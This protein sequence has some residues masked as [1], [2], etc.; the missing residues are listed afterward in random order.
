VSDAAIVLFAYNRPSALRRT[1]KSLQAA[2]T[3]LAH[4]SPADALIPLIVAIDGPRSDTKSQRI[5]A[6]VEK[7]ARTELPNTEVRLQERN[8]GLP[9]H[10]LETLDAVF[11]RGSVHRVIC[12][13]DD[14]DLSPTALIALLTASREATS[15]AHVIGASPNHRD[16]SLEHQ[17]LLVSAGAH[18]ASRALLTDYIHRF[19]L[20]GAEREGAYGGRDHEGIAAWSAQVARDAN[21]AAPQGTSQ[22]RIRELAWRTSGVPLV[23]LPL[24]LVTHHGLWGQHNTPWYALRT[25][26]LWQR[27]DRRPW[28]EIQPLIRASVSR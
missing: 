20:D 14:V 10:L 16:G 27:L 24:R 26:Q 5:A 9:A 11:D 22:D 15:P 17:A 25:G 7:I 1:I 2:R 6:T 19:S 3:T 28:E 4:T 8:R 12:V 13:E 23:G 21:V 18:Q